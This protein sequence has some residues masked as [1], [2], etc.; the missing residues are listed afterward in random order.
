MM[1]K[2]SDDSA[3]KVN[4]HR[5][6]G[7]DAIKRASKVVPIDGGAKTTESVENVAP[8]PDESETGKDEKSSEVFD[9]F[10]D[11]VKEKNIANRKRVR[12]TGVKKKD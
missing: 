9:R 6:D 10:L 2:S 12:G 5:E 8:D 11:Q 4:S 7:E 3:K 1:D